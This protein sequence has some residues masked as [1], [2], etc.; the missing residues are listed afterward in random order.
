MGLGAAFGTYYENLEKEAEKEAQAKANRATE[1]YDL[2]KQEEQE[3]AQ[4]FKDLDTPYTS[5]PTIEKPVM[6]APEKLPEPQYE[7]RDTTTEYT[8]DGLNITQYDVPNANHGKND[9]VDKIIAHR[10]S[11][12]NFDPRGG[13]LNN[14]GLGAH[15]T[16]NY[17]GSVHQVG[18]EMDKMW[19]AGPKGNSNSIGIEVVGRHLGV[20]KGWE[21]MTREQEETLTKLSRY[22]T[23]KY[24][25]S[26]SNIIP[27][28]D[29]AAKMP[30]EGYTVRDTILA[31]MR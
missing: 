30:T 7:L 18:Q 31:S 29:I 22:L 2:D 6:K 4:L 12:G 20:D 27:H 8:L 14:D 17:D 13:R 1:M 25:I 16:I 11:G 10:T 15:F 5:N 19:H 3:V 9:S 24:D 28:A 26:S 21:E 23:Q